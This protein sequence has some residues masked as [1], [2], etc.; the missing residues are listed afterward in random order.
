MAAFH[1]LSNLRVG[2]S[3]SDVNS[4]LFKVDH[5]V[6][7]AHESQ[8]EV[9]SKIIPHLKYDIRLIFH[10]QG[11]HDQWSLEACSKTKSLATVG[12]LPHV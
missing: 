9:F 12:K 7:N 6:L 10:N 1:E 8:R 2:T 11:N 5:Y 3:D 4:F